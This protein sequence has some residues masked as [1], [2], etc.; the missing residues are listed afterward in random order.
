MQPI[1]NENSQ[2]DMAEDQLEGEEEGGSNASPEEQQMYDQFVGAALH[3]IWGDDMS[4]QAI[5][6]K[7]KDEGPDRAGFAI[8]HTAAMLCRSIVGGLRKAG[9]DLPEDILFAGA[10]EV[11]ENLVEMASA[12]GI[13]PKGGEQQVMEV[14]MLEGTKAYADAEVAE[15]NVTPDRSAMAAT[16]LSELSAQARA[17]APKEQGGIVAKAKGG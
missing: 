8:G 14:A 9:R 7:I 1:E 5:L 13:I 6:K 17:M 10:Q 16:E 2:A 12:A 15:G 3:Q 4:H 11:V